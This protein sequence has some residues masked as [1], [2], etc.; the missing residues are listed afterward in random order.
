MEV[1]HLE[2]IEELQSLY[3]KK[4]QMEQTQY[5]KLKQA[6]DEEQGHYEE[7]IKQMQRM[8]E[9]AIEKLLNDFKDELQVVQD[10][11]DKA[12]RKADGTKM[13]YEEKLT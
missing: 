10:E 7:R 8:S 4:L 9:Q 12:K 11:Y 6:K 2:C 1:N 13:K 5:N 3:E